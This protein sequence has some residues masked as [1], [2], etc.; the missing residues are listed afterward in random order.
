MQRWRDPGDGDLV[1]WCESRHGIVACQGTVALASLRFRFQQDIFS[2]YSASCSFQDNLLSRFASICLHNFILVSRR[3]YSLTLSTHSSIWPSLQTHLPLTRPLP[4]PPQAALMP[5]PTRCSTHRTTTRRC[6]HRRRR[7]G[8]V[9]GAR[10][11]PAPTGHGS[12]A[13]SAS[14]AC[15]WRSATRSARPFRDAP[16]NSSTRGA[17]FASLAL[18]P[19][20]HRR[21]LCF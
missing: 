11:R 2:L 13:R 4:P 3:L 6:Y 1:L 9:T 17:L 16:A 18:S 19:I 21:A 10:R 8:S 7:L 12:R 15:T 14:R 5:R 20:V